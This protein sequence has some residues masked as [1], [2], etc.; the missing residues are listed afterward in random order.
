VSTT[1]HQPDNVRHVRA[2]LAGA[3]P[4]QTRTRRIAREP[5]CSPCDG[6]F[7]SL[8][9]VREDIIDLLRASVAARTAAAQNS[10][11]PGEDQA[12]PL[13]LL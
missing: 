13:P 7:L 5:S 11:G 10:I 3:E 2:V 8:A 1:G 12:A 4:G 9:A 6:P